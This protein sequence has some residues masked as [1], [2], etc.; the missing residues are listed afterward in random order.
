[1]KRTALLTVLVSVCAVGAAQAGSPAAGASAGNVP[2]RVWNVSR[3]PKLH[4]D[5]A[6]GCPA[7]IGADQDVVNTFAG[8]PLVPPSPKAGLICRYGPSS[9]PGTATLKRQ[10]RLGPTQAGV[11]ATVVGRLNLAAPSGVT[12]CPADFGLVAVIGFSYPA[13]ADVGLWY[14]ASGCQ[15]VDNGRIGAV[16]VGNPSFYNGFL[17][18]VDRLSPPVTG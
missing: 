8:P 7:S 5:V 10:A 3:S 1:M 16:E 13:R 9:N 2:G 11:L 14:Q 4:V 15:E 17:T 6:A 18:T 12:N